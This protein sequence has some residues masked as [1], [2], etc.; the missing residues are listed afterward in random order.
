MSIKIGEKPKE[1]S[2]SYVPGPGSYDNRNS[3]VL[4]QGRYSVGKSTRDPL[5]QS[6]VPGPGAY[7]KSGDIKL[8]DP[9]GKVTFGKDSRIKYE[10]SKTPG[11]GSYTLKPTFADVPK[12]LLPNMN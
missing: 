7:D 9:K 1:L 12:Y 2:N 5:S 8:K 6:F 10:N 3:W 4:G 11:P